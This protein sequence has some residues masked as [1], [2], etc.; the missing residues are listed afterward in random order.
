[1]EPTYEEWAALP[2]HGNAPPCPNCGGTYF[3]TS[4]CRGFL[5]TRHCHGDKYQSS[6]GYKWR[7]PPTIDDVLDI[8]GRFIGYRQ[9]FA[10]GRY[11]QH[12]YLLD[13]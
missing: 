2:E 13:R 7:T 5:K 11:P 9:I 12:K 6:C 3:G 8:I 4:N 1:M 10:E